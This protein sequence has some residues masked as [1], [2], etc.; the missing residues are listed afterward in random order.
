MGA[1]PI[2]GSI[3]SYWYPVYN[4][5]SNT[6]D[7]NSY[8]TLNAIGLGEE[9]FV[10]TGNTV[11]SDFEFNGRQAT[12]NNIGSTFGSGL[13]LALNMQ[14]HTMQSYTYGTNPVTGASTYAP[15]VVN[16]PLASPTLTSAP[17]PAGWSLITYNGANTGDPSLLGATATAG[18]PVTMIISAS[19][20]S[21]AQTWI[22]GATTQN[23][24]TSLT[25]GAA[26]FVFLPT[27]AAAFTFK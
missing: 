15:Q 16:Y 2:D 1:N 9:T 21:A 6:Q 27:A 14:G 26:Y 8:N 23:T 5:S 12:V 24:L 17:L 10:L 7:N 25:P 22:K 20:N 19:D 4:D 13:A 11:K 18:S 3:Q